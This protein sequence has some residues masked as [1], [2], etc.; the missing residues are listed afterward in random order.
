MNK[1][2]IL[3]A[4]F[5]IIINLLAAG[6]ASRFGKAKQVLE[7]QGETLVHRAA[8]IALQAGLDPVVV[9][10]GAYAGETQAAVAD[11]RVTLAHNPDW[12][13]GQSASVRIG[14]RALPEGV[15]AAVFMLVDQ[16]LVSASLIRRLAEVHAESLP[17]VVAPQA[18]GRR[19]NPVLFDRSIF[20]YLLELQGDQGGRQLFSKFAPTWVPWHDES[21][22]QE[23]DTP[24]DYQLLL[25]LD[26]P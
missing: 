17:P 23:I 14:V 8:R 4:I 24:E 2:I 10:T 15:G 1:R 20:A 11:L 9:V 19:A 12:Q 25:E 13:A 16:P 22:L 7:W 21:I 5:V 18:G 26:A 6:S 3:S